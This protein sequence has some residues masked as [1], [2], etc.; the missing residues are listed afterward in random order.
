MGAQRQ[1]EGSLMPTLILLRQHHQQRLHQQR[2]KTTTAE[3][4][5]LRDPLLINRSRSRQ[6]YYLKAQRQ[7]S[8]YNHPAI[9]RPIKNSNR[10]KM[11]LSAASDKIKEPSSSNRFVL[12]S[13]DNNAQ[14]KGTPTVG[15]TKASPN[16]LRGRS[17][18]VLVNS[19]SRI[20]GTNNFHVVPC[21]KVISMRLKFKHIPKKDL[22]KL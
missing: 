6:R 2:Q 12:Q 3:L 21:E 5:T 13:E 15:N 10:N 7:Q 20:V 11:Q 17:S 1:S 8:T 16:Y 19:I 14:V 9:N 18:S 4:Q 22:C